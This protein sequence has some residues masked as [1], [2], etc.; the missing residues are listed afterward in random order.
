[1]RSAGTGSLGREIDRAGAEKWPARSPGGGSDGPV[2]SGLDGWRASRSVARG[3]CAH[4]TMHA[5]P[6]SSRGTGRSGRDR[7]RR[8]RRGHRPT[9]EQTAVLR[10]VSEQVA[11]PLD[12]LAR[13]LDADDG[14]TA[15]FVAG[16]AKAGLARQRCFLAGQPAWVWLT[17]RGAAL[18]GTRLA[19]IRIPSL[20]HLT[21]RRAI[22]EVR[23]ELESRAPEGRWLCERVVERR[24]DRN[25]SI[26][27]ALFEIG[28]ER[29]AIEVEL[30]HKSRLA[31]QHVIAF[32]SNRYDAVVYFCSPQT[33][34]L[35]DEVRRSGCWPK[36]IV[37]SVPG[38]EEILAT[39]SRGFGRP[40]RELR[41]PKRRPWAPL[42][43]RPRAPR[44]W[45]RQLL[46]LISE[47][48][49]IPLDQLAGFLDC[50]LDRAERIAASLAEARFVK[51]G[52]LLAEEPDWVWLTAGGARLSETGFRPYLP[53][54]G[55]L[56]KLRAINAVRLQVESRDPA[57]RW[58][59]WRTL[60]REL[61]GTIPNA[62]VEIGAERHAIEIELSR[63]QKKQVAV[64]MIAHR[65]IKYDAV[66]CFCTPRARRFYERL[67]AENHLP[68]LLVRPLPPSA[69]GPASPAMEPA[70][71]RWR[72]CAEQAHAEGVWE[73]QGDDVPRR[74]GSRNLS[75]QPATNPERSEFGDDLWVEL[76]PLI[77]SRV[78]ARSNGRRLPDRSALSG[79]LY[80]ARNGIRWSQLPH[81]LGYGSGMSCWERLRR[82]ERAGVWADLQPLLK[83]RLDD[84]DRL[85][86]SRLG[87]LIPPSQ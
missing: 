47:Q 49:A 14:E 19:A 55:A 56:R 51:Q 64:G 12:Q 28:G 48:G 60:R 68:K 30:N 33:R 9:A 71:Q 20:R 5:Q 22:N 32:H 36:L 53:S 54:P 57:A 76:E 4:A 6:R 39:R 10:L 62:V 82:W 70:P 21:H 40:L 41:A 15:S 1:M 42:R 44:P 7:P 45:E 85:P 78:A 66:I 8:E 61:R 35:L 23:L 67:Q 26:P 86:W 58:I 31:L 83:E 72:W 3:A 37:R 43:K 38:L 46:A 11:I 24:L 77:S 2:E 25:A 74:R 52:R 18:S 87:P 34:P 79:I 17:S 84:G 29:H 69:E 73:R 27:D 50:D 13:F 63:R 59:G 81:E 80:V 65:S 75:W 16:L